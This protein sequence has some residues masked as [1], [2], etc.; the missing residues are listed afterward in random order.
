A[1]NG[2][3]LV[4]VNSP[5]GSTG[6]E[7]ATIAAKQSGLYRIEIRSFKK[8]VPT[9][10]YTIRL[11]KLF[12]QAEYTTKRLAAF[13]RV[14]VAVKHFHP[15][16]AYKDIDWDGALV[17]AVPQVKAAHTPNEY[18]QAVGNL[19][20]VLNDPV[21]KIADASIA[22]VDSAAATSSQAPTYYRM[23]DEY[24]VIKAA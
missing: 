3:T 21:T 5:N 16:L 6:E 15:Y 23:V 13:A 2:A 14:W 11:D 22:G 8:D 20:L 4:E 10:R 19:L 24:V 18:R 9:G 17:K 1:P 7:P 12:T